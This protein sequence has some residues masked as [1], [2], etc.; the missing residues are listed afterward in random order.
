MSINLAC[1][2]RLAAS[3]IFYGENPNP[4]EL[5]ENISCPVLGLYGAEDMRIN[6]HLDAHLS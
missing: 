6:M 1:R 4:I 2:T 5:V 3:V